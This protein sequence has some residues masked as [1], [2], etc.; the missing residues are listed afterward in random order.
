MLNCFIVLIFAHFQLTWL[1]L[2]SDLT[3][4]ESQ[5]KSVERIKLIYSNSMK[6]LK[7]PQQKSTVSSELAEIAYGSSFVCMVYLDCIRYL[8][9]INQTEPSTQVV[10]LLGTRKRKS[11]VVES[12]CNPVYEQNFLFLCHH[13]KDE[14]P[15]KL[16]IHDMKSNKTIGRTALSLNNLI[17]KGL[18]SF[19]KPI[20]VRIHQNLDCVLR[21]AVELR[22][23]Y[24][25]GFKAKRTP[26]GAHK[27]SF[28]SSGSA[29]RPD[30]EDNVIISE[31]PERDHI[32]SLDQMVMSTVQPFIRTMEYEP[33]PSSGPP[34][35]DT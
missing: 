27:E 33:E 7:Q 13:L 32:P 28:K 2:S 11:I 25:S 5:A 10:I 35:Q 14:Q 18:L 24:Q 15:L 6:T 19:D 17:A 9:K 1:K 4:L 8:P 29:D 21:V 22:V 12:N 16:E 31:P 3:K 26:V 34:K 23:L 20:H 30:A